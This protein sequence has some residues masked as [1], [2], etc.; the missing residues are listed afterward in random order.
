[1]A[2]LSIQ[3]TNQA[4]V[5]ASK[6]G[7]VLRANQALVEASKNGDI[8]RVQQM[9]SVPGIN[10]DHT[11]RGE[12]HTPLG[13]AAQFGHLRCCSLL[14]AAGA[15]VLAIDDAYFTPLH[16]SLIRHHPDVTDL[17][18]E[19]T[20]LAEGEDKTTVLHWMAAAECT[21]EH[22]LVVLERADAAAKD[23]EGRQAW[24]WAVEQSGEG[25]EVALLLREAADAAAD[26][27]AN[28]AA[29]AE[30]DT[31]ET[32][33]ATVYVRPSKEFIQ[34]HPVLLSCEQYNAQYDGLH[35]TLCSFAAATQLYHQTLSTLC[36][37]LQN[38]ILQTQH[39][40]FQFNASYEAPLSFTKVHEDFY[41]LLFREA[42]L[43]CDVV[44]KHNVMGARKEHQ[45]HLSLGTKDRGEANDICD[46]LNQC[47]QWEL[48]IVEQNSFGTGAVRVVETRLL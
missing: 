29:N 30:A 45:L 3:T 48:V 10:V 8:L 32:N 47:E 5:E 40:P 35:C 25:S 14:L 43:F 24:E 26:A 21:K 12:D 34:Q 38:T 41:I 13:Y 20:V 36:D 46:V 7:D 16:V 22:L 9:L 6:N 37:D 42:S 27:A 2:S 39:S 19:P 31:T 28:A 17:L 33:A 4:L 44:S 1:M 23:D 15:N 18:L 11:A